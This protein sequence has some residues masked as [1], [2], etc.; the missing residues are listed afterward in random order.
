VFIVI[1]SRRVRRY[2][3]GNQNPYI[4]EEQ[5]TQWPREEE[6]TTQ[7]PREEEQTTQWP[8]EEE[9]TTQ[10]PREE[11]QTTQWPKAKVQKVK[12]RSKNTHIKL[13]IECS[14]RVISE[15]DLMGEV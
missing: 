11:E 10:W 13:K 15:S 2:Q 1:T 14:G 5:T 3:R 12:Q 8:R 7:W 4:E 9:Q 6:Q